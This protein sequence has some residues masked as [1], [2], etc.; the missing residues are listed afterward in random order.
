MADRFAVKD[1]CCICP[2]GDKRTRR[3]RVQNLDPQLQGDG[4]DTALKG[5]QR[6]L[7]GA[8]SQTK[9]PPRFDLIEASRWKTSRHVELERLH[10]L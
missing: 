1:R 7:I 9:I 10:Q 4:R 3:H 2:R 8:P 5:A 6:R